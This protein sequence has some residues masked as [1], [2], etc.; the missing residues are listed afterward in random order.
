MNER[1]QTSRLTSSRPPPSGPSQHSPITGPRRN[2]PFKQ[3]SSPTSSQRTR[4]T[5]RNP[6]SAPKEPLSPTETN[7]KNTVAPPRIP[8]PPKNATHA[9]SPIDEKPPPEHIEHR[10]RPWTGERKGRKEK[11]ER[12]RRGNRK[13]RAFHNQSSPCSAGLGHARV[14]Y[15]GKVGFSI[16]SFSSPPLSLL[17]FSSSR[18]PKPEPGRTMKWG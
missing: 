9:F 6:R 2:D 1:N 4:P 10:E 14:R 17:D 16:R 18:P 8:N 15:Q 3:Q 11:R 12:S 13:P 5:S 7:T